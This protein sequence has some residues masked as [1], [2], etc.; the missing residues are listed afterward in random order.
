[1]QRGYDII[2]NVHGHAAALETLLAKLGYARRDGSWTHSERTAVF[3][4][5]F[6]DR[7]PENL[8]ACRIAMA[9]IEAGTALS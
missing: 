5:D 7:G 4:G 3:V 6:V 2:G 8:R 1:M 9:M